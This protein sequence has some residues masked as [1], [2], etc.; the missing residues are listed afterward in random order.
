MQAYS[1]KF[2]LIGDSGVGKSQL[3]RRFTKNNFKEN[4][5]STVGMEFSTRQL[6]FEK[7]IIKAQIWD[8]AGIDRSENMT[9]AYFK[10][11]V[12]AMLI[13]DINNPQSFDNLKNIWLPQLLKYGHEKISCLLV[14][15]KYDIVE[16]DSTTSV[17]NELAISFA[18]LNGMD[19]ITT[20]AK[21]GNNVDNSFR[22]LILSVA[23]LL[24]DVAT[25]LE[26]TGLPDGWIML[27]RHKD[28]EEIEN[29][30][31]KSVDSLSE[32]KAH[33]RYPSTSSNNGN[34]I[35]TAGRKVDISS[36]LRSK[37]NNKLED[38]GI[39]PVSSND[40]MISIVYINYWTGEETMQIPY[41]SAPTGLIYEYKSFINNSSNIDEKAL[42]DTFSLTDRYSSG[43]NSHSNSRF[44]NAL[45][46]PLES[47]SDELNK[48][49]NS[50]TRIK[51]VRNQNKSV[52][53]ESSAD[54][55]RSQRRALDKCNCMVM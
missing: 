30:S 45:M 43:S 51:S 6:P 50:N 55:V 40:S 33:D 4:S 1:L 26:L 38:F 9:K 24:P 20:S 15:N 44:H 54:S 19:F 48:N 34:N 53:R 16:N 22:R 27:Y 7:C 12:G 36:A 25:H 18:E 31:P 3:S 41:Q 32:S 29:S 14:G 21:N 17:S 46:Q 8:T 10:D 39:S 52:V 13:Y 37:S 35:Y 23:K 47:T 28:N 49:I 2:V 11:T 5:S 42:R